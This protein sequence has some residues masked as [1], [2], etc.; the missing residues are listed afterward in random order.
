MSTT[1]PSP[2]Q[3]S[4]AEEKFDS[5]DFPQTLRDAQ[6]QAAGLYAELRAYRATLPWSRDHTPDGVR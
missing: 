5:H 6:R 2:E 4:A 3:A 1:T